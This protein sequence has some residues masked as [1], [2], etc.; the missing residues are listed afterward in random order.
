MSRP[1]KWN[2]EYV[3]ILG[4][5]AKLGATDVELAE[6]VD[7]S[8]RTLQYWKASKPELSEALMVGKGVADE[9]VKRSLYQRA[10]GYSHPDVHI[11]N[12]QG[13]ITETPLIKHYPPDTTAG[14]FWLKN[15]RP[16]EFRDKVEHE[17]SGKLTL[18]QLVNGSLTE[19]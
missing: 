9:R 6:I 10:V 13:V 17:H 18:E 14:I 8:V 16:E 7:V 4:T 2:D 15:R 5:A 3:H 12:Y 1:E 19:E 11:T